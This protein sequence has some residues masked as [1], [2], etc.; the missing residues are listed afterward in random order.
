MHETCGMRVVVA[1]TGW[2]RLHGSPLVMQ[3]TDTVIQY[4]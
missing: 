3:A 2:R 1:A 4:A